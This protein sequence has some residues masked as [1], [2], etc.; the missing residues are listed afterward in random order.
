M[1]L[2]LMKKIRKVIQMENNDKYV[3]DIIK[4]SIVLIIFES[5]IVSLFFKERLPLLIGLIIGGGLAIVSFRIIYLSILI[6]IAKDESKA[7]R[8]MF[9]SYGIRYLVYG[10][11]LYLGHKTGYYNIFTTALGLLTIKLV[12]YINNFIS[13]IKGRKNVS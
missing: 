4:K 3:E 6:A 7:E 8:F 5:I 11:V 9:L 1:K 13:L 12:L 2:I 10:I